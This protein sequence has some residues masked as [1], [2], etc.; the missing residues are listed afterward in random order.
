MFDNDYE[1]EDRMR[2]V[3][4]DIKVKVG[5][6]EY[7]LAPIPKGTKGCGKV[8]DL[9]EICDNNQKWEDWCGDFMPSGYCF[10]QI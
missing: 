4:M 2:P 8:C 7:M 9:C 6:D 10:K 3:V 5:A 1:K